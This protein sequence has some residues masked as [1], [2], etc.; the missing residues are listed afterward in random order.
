MLSATVDDIGRG[1]SDI[2]TAEYN[3]NNSVWFEMDPVDS[4]GSPTEDVVHEF[5]AP[6]TAGIYQFCVRGTDMLGHVGDPACT[7]LVV[8]DP[9]G[10]FVT[11]GGWIS[12]QPGAYLPD[13]S[14]YGKA[15]FG[16][17]SKYKKG[18]RTPSGN[19]EFKFQS[20]NLNFHSNTYDWL[21][22][23]GS[24]Y[25]KFKGIGTINGFGNYRFMIWAGD[26]APDT[27]RIKIWEEDELTAMETVIYD[28]GYD[29]P[30]ESG[31]IVIHTK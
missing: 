17:V 19:T 10:G 4:Y 25:A 9:D 23:T 29:Q 5:Y 16:F 8:Y 11:G 21:V 14:L 6:A 15:N 1:N 3:F 26:G 18:A 20:G 31:N 22:V 24:D 12:S 7:L 13:P 28:N 30:I 2:Q 27:F